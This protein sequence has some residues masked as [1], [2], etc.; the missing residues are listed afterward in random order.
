M[1]HQIKR[2]RSTTCP[3]QNYAITMS[4]RTPQRSANSEN[5]PGPIRLRFL[6]WVT[7]FNINLRSYFENRGAQNSRRRP[8]QK[9]WFIWAHF[10][11]KIIRIDNPTCLPVPMRYLGWCVVVGPSPLRQIIAPRSGLLK[12]DDLSTRGVLGLFS[13]TE[14][15]APTRGFSSSYVPY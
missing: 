3:R 8:N 10:W 11:R 9:I 4:P 13:L 1:Y 6:S 7:Y 15:I 5:C 12:Q 14:N 2:Q